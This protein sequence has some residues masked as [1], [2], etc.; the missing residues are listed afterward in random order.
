MQAPFVL[1]TKYAKA[2]LRQIHI[3]DTDA[4]HPDLKEA[5]LTNALVNLRGLPDTFDE[6][7]L[8]LEYQNDEFKQFRADRGS[9]LQETD[10][11]FRQ[12]A[13]TAKS[14]QKMRS[15]VNKTIVGRRRDGQHPE[16]DAGFDIRS[17]ADQLHRSK[18][19]HSSRPDPSKSYYFSKNTAPNIVYKGLRQLPTAVK[20]YNK[21]VKKNTVPLDASTSDPSTGV[22]NESEQFPELEAGNEVVNKPFSVGKEEATLTLDLSELNI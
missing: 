21:S 3:I 5:Y 8:L 4:T 15:A 22:G 2:L 13:L 10:V 16:K 1:K 14:L 12:H 7:D 20:L 18:S 6:M 19:T 11:M 9:S 17:L